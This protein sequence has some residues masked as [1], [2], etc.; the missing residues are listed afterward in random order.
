MLPPV[1]RRGRPRAGAASLLSR[2]WPLPS[3]AGHAGGGAP[4]VVGAPG[5]RRPGYTIAPWA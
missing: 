3:A 1:T 5:D 2:R 4:E